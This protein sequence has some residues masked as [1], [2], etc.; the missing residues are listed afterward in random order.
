MVSF[1][2]DFIRKLQKTSVFTLLLIPNMNLA[3]KRMML[4]QRFVATPHE[5]VDCFSAGCVDGFQEPR[6]Q[7]H[8]AKKCGLSNEDLQ[9]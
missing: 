1:A 8:V 7:N 5:N 4:E 2:A 3:D 6:S 9:G